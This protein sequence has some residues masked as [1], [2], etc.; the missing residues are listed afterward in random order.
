[1]EEPKKLRYTKQFLIL[2]AVLALIGASWVSGHILRHAIP[3]LWYVPTQMPPMPGEKIG[4]FSPNSP[5]IVGGV[6]ITNWEPFSWNPCGTDTYYTSYPAKRRTADGSLMQV[7]K[8]SREI[9]TI[10]PGQLPE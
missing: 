7:E 5:Q 8:R 3:S 4:I 1:M 9:Y 2:W 10:P 6:P